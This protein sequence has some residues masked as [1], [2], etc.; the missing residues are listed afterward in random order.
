MFV[1]R[2]LLSCVLLFLGRSI[3]QQS[4][5]RDNAAGFGIQNMDV[6]GSLDKQVLVD[7]L[8]NEDKWT[9]TRSRDEQVAQVNAKAAQSALE[10]IVSKADAYAPKERSFISAMMSHSDVRQTMAHMI[11]VGR[12]IGETA[13]VAHAVGQI[14]HQAAAC[15]PSNGH[16]CFTAVLLEGGATLASLVRHYFVNTA[17][18]LRRLSHNETQQA[19]DQLQQQRGA[20]LDFIEGGPCDA[21]APALIKEGRL[22]KWI[23][24]NVVMGGID[25]MLV[26][27]SGPTMFVGPLWF[28]EG[29]Y[30]NYFILSFPI[31]NHKSINAVEVM[32]SP[33]WGFFMGKD[34]DL[35]VKVWLVFKPSATDDDLAH[36]NKSSKAIKRKAYTKNV[37]VEDVGVWAKATI[38][39]SQYREL[40]ERP[41]LN[42][43]VALFEIYQSIMWPDFRMLRSTMRISVKSQ[44][45]SKV[46]PYKAY[47]EGA[48]GMWNHKELGGTF[49]K[50]QIAAAFFWTVPGLG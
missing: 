13:E 2:E 22:P 43:D 33:N 26:P 49:L 24:C 32:L 1:M 7:A 50:K 17:G 12:G 35:L 23:Y 10:E 34:C 25:V 9:T 37:V 19:S 27:S 45:L 8:R 38:D 39:T 28:E 47:L 5:E 44:N 3:R 21:Q 29:M 48:P 30:F 14:G 16:T 6:M 46:A 20:F 31:K 18:A 4:R 36:V 11:G 42:L 41:Q 15:D 40:G